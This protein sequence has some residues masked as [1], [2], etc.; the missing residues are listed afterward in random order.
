[1]MELSEPLDRD[2]WKVL[3]RNYVD[4]AILKISDE[5][6]GNYFPLQ[7]GTDVLIAGWRGKLT[8]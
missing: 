4:F 1:M 6:L 7:P 5:E 8:F 3:G 2:F